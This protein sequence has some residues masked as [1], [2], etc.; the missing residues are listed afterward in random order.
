MKLKKLT[1]VLLACVMT[2]SLAACGEGNS[3]DA[4]KESTAKATSTAGIIT[5]NQDPAN[6][7]KTDETLTVGLASEPSILYAAAAGKSENEAMI[8]NSAITDTLVTFDYG[9][10]EVKPNLATEWEWV[11]DTHL[12]FTLRDDVT[13]SDG[14]PLV[15]DDVAYSCNNVW[16]ALNDTNTTG[17]YLVG[18]VADDEHTVTIEFN[19][20]APDFVKFMCWTDF[21]IVSEDEV[22]AAGGIEAVS[23]NPVAG[24]GPYKFVE[25]K[26]GQY[27]KLERN[28]EYW[29]K[30]YV[31]YY[32]EIVFTFTNDAAAREMAVESGD[33]DIAYQIPVSQASTYAESD[34]VQTAI[35]TFGQTTHLWYNM[36][37]KADATA[38]ENVRAAIDKALDFEAIAQVGTA[39]LQ[40]AADS[41]WDPSCDYY[42]AAYT[43]EERAV[44]VDA[45]KELLKE[46]GYADGLEITIL[47]TADMSPVFTVMQAN[48]AEVGITLNINT[49][50]VA[51]FVEGAFG[52][53]YDLICVGDS[54]SV[55]TPETVMTFLRKENA[56]GPGMVIG[57]PK[58]SSDEIQSTIDKLIVEPDLDKS[59]ELATSLDEMMKEQTICSNLYSEMTA[60][61]YANGLKGY[62][63]L[64][65][66]YP[67]V[68]HFYK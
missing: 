68:T 47:G 41:Y 22:N 16:I 50:D 34:A 46:A 63:T 25:W 64:E 19:T 61:V 27:V 6:T 36:G 15:A 54:P 4:S 39:G 10:N 57:G 2:L 5:P 65:R 43:P 17:K 52:G 1:T 38:D 3:K 45:A 53:D 58:W 9:S 49:P 35:Y 56:V 62:D 29:N 18:A 48:L 20:V 42:T 66:G 23:T 13:M 30:D 67:D 11:D 21:G 26:N 12:K 32:K 40:K 59:K 24:C 14:T 7:E 60:T 44:D 51:Q 8:I 33:A 31:G 37:E 55:R 28:E